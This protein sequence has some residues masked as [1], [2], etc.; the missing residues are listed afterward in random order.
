MSKDTKPEVKQFDL[1]PHEKQ[2]LQ[3]INQQHQTV[4]GMYLSTIAGDRLGIRV[5][6]NTQF[7]VDD[8]GRLSVWE[9]E[10]DQQ[11]DDGDVV[12]T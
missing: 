1:K 7:S 8:Q 12:T 6:Q 5:S 3:I 11:S 2:M 10:A 9:V 4:L